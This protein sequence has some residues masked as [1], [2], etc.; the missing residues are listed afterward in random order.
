M[1]E[2]FTDRARR[3]IAFAQE[4]AKR[5]H[6]NYLG[7]EHI[8]L[9]LVR[10]GAGVAA[11]VLQNLGVDLNAIR[12]EVEAASPPG[13]P[14]SEVIEV[15][16]VP[17]AKRVLELAFEEAR[18][19][20]H[21]YIGT[22]HLLLGL[23][24]DSNGLGAKILTNLGLDL[25]RVR[26]EIIRLL[27]GINGIPAYTAPTGSQ[28]GKRAST[29]PTLDTFARDLTQLAKEGKLDPVIG[30]ND[31]IDRVIQIL[32]RRTKNNPILIGEP[33]VGKTAIV[34]GLAQRV[35][36][37][38]VPEVLMSKRVLCL[39]LAAIVAGTKYRGEFEER[40]K[41]VLNEIKQSNDVILFIDEI[42]NLVGAGAAEGAID[43]ASILK[44]ALARGEIQCIGA[45]TLDAHR[46]HIEKDGA[47]ERR[48]QIIMV[49][50][51]TVE[52]TIEILKGIKGKYED[53]HKVRI[54][55]EAVIAAAKLAH[56][57]IS[58]RHLP[59]KAVDLMD[60]AASK[61]RLQCMTTPPRVKEIEEE[62]KQ[63][64]QQKEEAIKQQRFE[65]AAKLRDK[66]RSLR[67]KLN[68]VRRQWEENY[69]SHDNYVTQE[70]IA[71][72]VSKATGIPLQKLVESETEKLLRIEEELHKRIVGQD[73]AIAAV[74]R[75]LR[76]ARTG[77]KDP[78]RPMGSFI[79][80]G[81]TGVGKTELARTLAEFLFD[82][83]DA[84]IQIDM[85]EFM[86]RF[87]VSRLVGAPPGY[88]GYEEGGELTEK[89]RRRP[90]S[91]ILL[92]EIE[93]AHPDVFNIL[94]QVLE[95]GRLTDNL[96]HTVNFRNSVIIMT[97]NIGAKDI[98]NGKSL[99]FKAEVSK[100]LSYEEIKERVTNEMKKVFN[101]E[102]LNRLDEII[103][104][105]PLSPDDLKKIIKLLIQRLN[106]Q[107]KE[108]NLELELN[109]SAISFITE[110]G[111]DPV[112]GARPLR[113]V[114]QKYIEDPLS[115]E[116]LRGKF[117]N[118]GKIQ[119][120]IKE[121][122]ANFQLVDSKENE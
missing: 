46:K 70:D 33:G 103:V 90:Y 110:K 78:K 111:F 40:L 26:E 25:K 94:L 7:P 29:T 105:H 32:G 79:F 108:Q 107:L 104:F 38:K 47:L 100:G 102:F 93:K 21:N 51:P 45:T 99:G 77:I 73:E 19:L 62:M 76:R 6:H 28:R 119:V 109:D 97:S 3:V 81:P 87:A 88:V 55:E 114:I 69:R 112:Y 48:F 121:E 34:E 44:P 57:Y 10:E 17:D 37:G 75:A 117:P 16:F 52:E 89:V 68:N 23:I 39:D 20:H 8:L 85:S 30:R 116:L 118:R 64:T 1:F 67:Q 113:R 82:N 4:E 53:Y 66:E 2:R 98:F 22:E 5:L 91:V 61:V 14:G 12:E 60:E 95:D 35:V 43:A 122:K 42:H 18:S 41:R 63:I 120:D 115:E 65:E 9:G 56:R 59:D 36:D 50:E 92:D 86:E 13:D 27:G 31:E 72:V 11:E 84:L 71:E 96:G 74:A 80:L 101:P 49:N 58:D 24:K 15:P 83:E 54:S 106:K